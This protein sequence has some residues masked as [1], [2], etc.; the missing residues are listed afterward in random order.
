VIPYYKKGVFYF[1]NREKLSNFA[2]A[3]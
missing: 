1:V 3:F 2:G